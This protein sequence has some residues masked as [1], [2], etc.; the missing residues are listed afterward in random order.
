MLTTTQVLRAVVINDG[1]VLTDACKNSKPKQPITELL[2]CD[3]D[4]YSRK[5]RIQLLVTDR[6]PDM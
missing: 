4:S 1:I 2:Y 6:R 5:Y 3:S